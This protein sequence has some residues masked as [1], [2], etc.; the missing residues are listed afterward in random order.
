MSEYDVIGSRA[1]RIDAP[2]KV[3]GRALFADDL[4]KTGQLYA[5]ILHSPVAHARIKRIDVSR[6]KALPGV[7]DVV[8]CRE[9]GTVPFG[10][11]PARYDETIFCHDRVRYAGDEVAA[12]A[13]QSYE[14][15]TQAL[16]LIDVDYEELPAVLNAEQAMADGAPLVHERYEGNICSQ[17][18]H[19]FGDVEQAH[20]QAAVIVSGTLRSK[21]QN[22]AFIEPQS[23]LAYV[24]LRGRLTLESSTQ[25]PHYVQR[26]LAMALGVPLHQVRVK[27]PYVGGGFGPKASCGTYEL[28]ACLLALRTGRPVKI[29]LSREE[30]F[31]HAR[32]RHEFTHSMSLGVTPE[33]EFLFLDHHCVLDGGAYASFGIATVYYA[34]SLLGGPYHLK[35]MRFDGYRTVSNRPACGAQ[36]GHG[37][38]H[39]RALFETLVDRAARE[40]GVD[41]VE[42]R[43]RNVMETGES[44][45]NELNM[46]SLGMRECLE[47]VRDQSG[48]VEKRSRPRAHGHGIGAACGFFVSGAGYPI[49][50]SKT[51]HCTIVTKVDEVGG[52]VVVL[53]GAAEIG[54]GCDT[55]MAMITA[56]VLGIDLAD[57]R[58]RSGDSDLSVDLGAYSSRTTLMTGHAAREAAL[59]VKA[60]ILEVLAAELGC[61]ADD[62]GFRGGLLVMRPGA[63]PVDWAALR[64]EFLREHVG[65]TDNPEDEALTFREASRI[66][67]LK[68]G[69]IVG[70][71]SYRPPA[72]GGSYKGAAVGTSPAYGCSAQIAEVDVDL[73]TGQVRVRKIT[74]AHDCG[75]AIN[76]TQVEG[77]MHGS[78][79]MGLGEALFEEVQFD[80]QGRVLN[81]NLADYK[82]P[83][84]LDMPELDSIIVESHEPNG[85]FGAKEVG[86]GGIMP[87]IPAILNAIYDATGVRINELPVTPE[88]IIRALKSK[89]T[90]SS[91]SST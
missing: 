85:P 36:R 83:T 20:E 71:G 23:A 80:G 50:R 1:A 44:T 17:V 74:G 64:K 63:A 58:V 6:A 79:S 68:K 42:L 18:H 32:A 9:A 72:L 43:L 69:S 90:G 52:G 67:F 51:Y 8:T 61:L 35:N 56:E 73:E 65:F 29:T 31:L 49:Y 15:A 48:W 82:I 88:R 2:D 5:A 7:S 66:A 76:K 75:F 40:M 22:G 24:D 33:G 25:A 81:P 13:A 54:Q 87:T 59:H 28:V 86:E 10:V 16:E 11:S 60:Q 46:S 53:S 89:A 78:M 45:I 3:T 47:A 27:K 70:T 62:L 39:A 26:T 4:N 57:V 37:A 14:I 41:A 77:Q 12:V 84:A 34:N 30:V 21:M 19:H 55:M 38:V 91:R